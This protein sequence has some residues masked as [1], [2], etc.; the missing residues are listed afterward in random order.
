MFGMIGFNFVILSWYDRID[1]KKTNSLLA[2][3]NQNLGFI[4][5]IFISPRYDLEKMYVFQ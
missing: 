5:E 2:N 3:E 1:A 4:M